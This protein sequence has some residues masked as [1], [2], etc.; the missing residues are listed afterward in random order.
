MFQIQAKTKTVKYH[1]NPCGLQC[2]MS[3]RAIQG[4]KHISSHLQRSVLSNHVQGVQGL[5]EAIH[6]QPERYEC[7]P[8]SIVQKGIQTKP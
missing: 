7:F 3:A 6:L 5:A 1:G 8:C 4:L 2:D